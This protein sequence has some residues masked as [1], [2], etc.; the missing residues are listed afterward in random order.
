MTTNT[1]SGDKARSYF[2]RVWEANEAAGACEGEHVL[3]IVIFTPDGRT[4]KGYEAW[5]D[6]LV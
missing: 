1:T 3:I 5:L 2:Q 4:R 6:G